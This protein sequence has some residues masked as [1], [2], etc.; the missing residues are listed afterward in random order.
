MSHGVVI[1]NKIRATDADALNRSAVCASDLDNGYVFELLTQSSTTGQGE[2]WTATQSAGTL[3]NIWMAYTPEVVT[4]V[5]GSNKFR[6]ID[7]DAR[8][9]YNVAGDLIDCFRPMPGDIIELTSDA[10]AN[11]TGAASAYAVVASGSWKLTWAAAAVSGLSL[12]YI[13]TTTYS[14]PSGTISDTQE[15]TIYKFQVTAVS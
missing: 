5:S 4:T 13:S 15:A 3:V 14:I 11:G 12:K 2:V 7:N 10:F 9:F 8:N 1:P 6:G